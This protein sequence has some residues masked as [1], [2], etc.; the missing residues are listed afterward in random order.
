MHKEALWH[1]SR[2][3]ADNFDIEFDHVTFGYGEKPVLKDVSFTLK[4]NHSYALVGAS[5]SGKSTI[6]KLI[7]GFYRVD[8]G[9]IKIGGFPLE[10]YSEKSILGN[11]AFVFQDVKL[12]KTSLYENVAMANVS[13]SREKVME[14]FHRA[15][16]DS[17]LDKFND[18]EKTIIGSK[19]VYLSGG[20]KQRIGI[21]RAI[22]KNAR[23]VIMDEASAAVDPE[24]EHELQKAFAELMKDKTVIM[25]AHRLTSVRN[26]DEILV[27]EDGQVIERG[28]DSELMKQES[29]YKFFQDLY[30][31]ANEWRVRE[32]A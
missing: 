24:N 16:C 4:Q 15:G 21:A 6:A 10:D 1:G 26:V 23:I 8:Q 30:A 2:E 31:Q 11:I 17:I 5:G 27:I 14:A 18:R 3:M 19:G 29:R 12:F 28:S 9:R 13:A 32:H 22:L 7:S 25:I 20:E